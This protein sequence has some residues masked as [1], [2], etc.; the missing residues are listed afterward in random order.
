M[1]RLSFRLP[2][3]RARIIEE[4]ISSPRR[5]IP[6]YLC[7]KNNN[8][9]GRFYALFHASTRPFIS[10]GSLGANVTRLRLPNLPHRALTMSFDSSR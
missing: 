10:Y 9:S 4:F 1:H 2:L 8:S 3:L 5:D 6:R 7:A